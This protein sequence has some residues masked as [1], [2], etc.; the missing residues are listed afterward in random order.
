MIID[1]HIHPFCKEITWPDLDK[2]ADVMWGQGTIKRKRMRPFLDA[3]AN[4]TSIKD[5]ISLMDKFSIDKSVIV[6]FN[7][8]TA[9]GICIAT[10]DDVANLEAQYP[11]RLIGFGCVDVPAPEA[12]DQLDYAI[13]SLG[14]KGIKLVPPVQKFDISDKKYDPLWKKMEDSNIILWTHGGHQVSTRGSVAKFGHPLLVDELAMRHPDLITI[15]GHMG[16]PWFWDTYSVVLRHSNV[17]VDVSAHS[18]LYN[19]F[20]WDAYTKYNIEH[21]VI[22]GS[23]YPLCHWNQIIPAVEDLPISN[24]FRKKIFKRNAEKVLQIK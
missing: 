7:I 3:V 5:Y 12:M 8:T 4:K 20:P 18:E 23:D 13:N 16:T 19:Y 9:Y 11:D 21:K 1:I 10:N 15:I 24:S 17:Y 22:F 2:V 6:S 14:L